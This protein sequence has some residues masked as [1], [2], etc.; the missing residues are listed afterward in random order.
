MIVTRVFPRDV[1][2]RKAFVDAFFLRLEATALFDFNA[3]F[4]RLE[5][6]ALFDFNAFFAMSFSLSYGDGTSS[7]SRL[8]S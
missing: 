6:A 7:S 4:L 5:A 3:F 2:I 8:L 1:A